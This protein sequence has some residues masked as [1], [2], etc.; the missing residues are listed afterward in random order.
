MGKDP[1]N[2]VMII[3]RKLAEECLVEVSA[4]DFTPFCYV[5]LPVTH[6]LNI[7]YCLLF[8]LC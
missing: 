2:N 3:F 1:V 4:S 8:K 6:E 5:A 7:Y